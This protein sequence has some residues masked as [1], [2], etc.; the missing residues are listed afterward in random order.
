MS[1]ENGELSAVSSEAGETN[2]ACGRDKLRTASQSRRIGWTVAGEGKAEGKSRAL[3][4]R[5]QRD[6]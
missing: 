4:H 6:V 5:S 3:T 2:P 1:W